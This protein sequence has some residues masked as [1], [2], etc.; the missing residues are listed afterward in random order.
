MAFEAYLLQDQANPRRRRRRLTF[1]LSVGAHAV[2]L[3]AAVGYSFW[4]VEELAPPAVTVTLLSAAAIPPPPPPPPPL[5]GGVQA[6]KHKVVK[7]KIEVTPKPTE[8]VQPKVEEKE[9]P[10]EKPEPKL[11]PKPEPTGPAGSADGVQGGVKDGTKGGVVGGKVGGTV[12]APPAPA[13]PAP[14]FLPPQMGERQTIYAPEPDVPTQLL[15]KGANYKVGVKICVGT[16]GELLS[17]TLMRGAHP[18]LD[19]NVLAAVKKY[20]FKPLLT[21]TGTGVPFCFVRVFD[22]RIE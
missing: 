22:F 14:K 15:T 13:A 9:T 10:Q 8:L 7:P 3:A 4:H 16:A 19:A 12:G 2:L 1:T 11:E 17:A 18:T 5:G 21:G 6:P 20:R